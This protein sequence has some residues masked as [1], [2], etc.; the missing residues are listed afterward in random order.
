MTA[1]RHDFWR[2]NLG[3]F[4]LWA[5]TGITGCVAV[6]GILTIGIF[7]MPIVGVLLG[8]AILLTGRRPHREFTIVGLLLGPAL[9]LPF[10]GWVLATPDTVDGHTPVRW[11]TFL[12]F[13]VTGLACLVTALVLFVVLGRR[14]HQSMRLGAVRP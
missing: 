12:P 14:A 6:A 4:T 9:L 7:V 11:T 3:A 5:L 1:A 13:A 10:I 2:S 8:A